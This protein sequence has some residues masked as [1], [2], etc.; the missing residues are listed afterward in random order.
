MKKIIFFMFIFINIFFI[1]SVNYTN[2]YLYTQN[3]NDR[4]VQFDEDFLGR[5]YT[6]EDKKNDIAFGKER[7]PSNE[8]P[9]SV[10]KFYY[11]NLNRIIFQKEQGIILMVGGVRLQKLKVH[12]NMN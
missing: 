4:I 3:L 5:I 10:E 2:E 8:S 7:K 9:S 6:C 12:T 11:D 1:N